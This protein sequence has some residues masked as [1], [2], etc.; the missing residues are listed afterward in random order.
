ME[1]TVKLGGSNYVFWGGRE[2]FSSSLNTD[3][4][5]ELDHL[6]E[7]FKM[8]VR[9]KSELGSQMTLLIE[10]KPKHTMLAGHAYS[11]DIMMASSYQLLGSID[12]NTGEPDLGWDTDNF[13]MSVVHTTEVM[14]YVLKT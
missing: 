6:A 5:Q 3:C 9:W 10:P 4:R 1:V 11:H 2:G 7:F 13:T 8:A 14:R 12:A